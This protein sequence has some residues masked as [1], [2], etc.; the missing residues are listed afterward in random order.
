MLLEIIN[1]KLQYHGNSLIKIHTHLAKASQ[2]N[3]LNK[4]FMKKELSQRWNDFNGVQVQRD[5]YSAFLI[6]NINDD[7]QTYNEEKCISRFEEFLSK[8]HIEIK[9][10]KK[11]NII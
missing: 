6:M 5:L 9:R 7:L 2:Y 3:H 4:T 11:M 8:H 1:R 10:C